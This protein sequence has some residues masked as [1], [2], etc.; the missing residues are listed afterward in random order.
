M[1]S[2]R[3][4]LLYM[5]RAPQGEHGTV[6]KFV[7]ETLARSKQ[8]VWV[9]KG[10]ILAKKVCQACLICRRLNKKLAGQLMSRIREESLTVCRPWTYVALDFAGPI[11]VKG[12]V[13]MRAKKKC[14]II[15]YCCR[16]TKAVCLLATCGYDTASFLLKHEEFVATH[17]APISLVSDRGTQL[18]SAGRA[19]AEKES[20]AQDSPDKW[21][22]KK[23]TSSNSASSWQFVPIGS[24]HY[25]GLPEST[26]KV[27]KKSLVLALNP[28]VELVY[29]ELVTLLA[30]ISYSIN[31]RPLGLSNTS[32]SSEQEDTMLPLTPN[33]LLLGRSS[34]LSPPLIYS[35][36]QKFCSRLAYVSQ[37][38]QDWWDRWHKSVLPTLFPYK[39]WKKRQEN[40]RVGDIVMLRYPGH[41]KDDYCLAKVSE[42][43]PDEEGLVRTCQVQY[44]KK[45]PK[46]ALKVY[47]SKPLISEK[48]TVHRLHPLGL[49]DEAHG[50]DHGAVQGEEK[51][52]EVA[53]D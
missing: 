7:A 41:F 20:E 14:R 4:A 45:N 37:V 16:S 46:E 1:P 27:L 52:V 38:E 2:S 15:V 50:H 48:V 35:E 53:Q 40:I 34:D 26:V 39:K 12:A 11:K 47:K 17:G 43:Y 32:S 13:N 49:A 18:V 25:N 51:G 23:I 28:G 44:R 42:V 31:A 5:V 3:A 36:D 10:R 8:S 30:K 6:H 21:D 9:V 33:M 29:P 19:L 22:W 24:Q